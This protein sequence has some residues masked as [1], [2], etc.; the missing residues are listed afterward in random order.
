MRGPDLLIGGW[1]LNVS[2]QRP[3]VQATQEETTPQDNWGS[4]NR[5]RCRCSGVRSNQGTQPGGLNSSL[6]EAVAVHL[7]YHGRKGKS[8]EMGK[9]IDR[10]MRWCFFGLVV[11][12][13]K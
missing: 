7:I 3:D 2:D 9:S 10:D 1:L 4:C 5:R 11:S 8:C 13:H 12:R 6:Y